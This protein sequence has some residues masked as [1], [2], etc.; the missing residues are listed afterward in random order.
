MKKF[1]L[2]I[3]ALIT[4]S[5]CVDGNKGK[6]NELKARVDSLE[7][8]NASQKKELGEMNSFL[9]ALSDGLDSIAIHEEILLTNNKG[10]EGIYVDRNQL[11]QNL[12]M[13]ENML[14]RQKQRISSLVDSLKSKGANME[15]LN[16]LVIHLNHQLD[17]KNATIQA[18]KADLEM[19]KVNIEQLRNKVSDLTETNTKLNDKVKTQVKIQVSHVKK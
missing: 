12:E 18:L 4:I 13:F 10:K 16:K 15:K 9:N 17:E 1:V 14:V 11:K 8:V 19:K 7:K 2:L 6:E 5:S 3:I